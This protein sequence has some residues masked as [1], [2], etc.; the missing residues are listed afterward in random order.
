MTRPLRALILVS[1]LAALAATAA[2]ANATSLT[3][4]PQL[5]PLASVQFP[6]RAFVLTA[7]VPVQLGSSNV[8]V[9]ENG[10]PVNNVSV[11]RASK[12]ASGTFGAVLVV[13]A[14]DSMRGAAI[15]GAVQAA[16]EF[17]AHKA[18]N[19][20]LGVVT[21]NQTVH[22]LVAPTT[23]AKRVAA[24]LARPP[25]LV[26]GTHLYDAAA[27][28]VGALSRAK[29]R[30]GSLV[31]LTDGRDTRSRLS[32]AEVAA[33]ARAAH[34]RVFAVGLRSPQYTP[35]PLRLIA[36]ETGAAYAEAGSAPAL[37]RIYRALSQRLA[38]EY[39]LRYRSLAAPATNVHVQVAAVGVPG[40]A[41][42]SY[43]TPALPT[44][45]TPPFHRSFWK[46][47]VLAPGSMVVVSLL[48]ALFA[49]YAVRRILWRRDLALSERIGAFASERSDLIRRQAT[50]P[51]Q[52]F[53][54]SVVPA[55]ER[56]FARYTW[57]EQF[58]QELEI[59]RF[60]VG[61]V[62]LATMTAAG[63]LLLA[64]VL[65][66]ASPILSV[67]ALAVPLGIHTLYKTKLKRIR[68]AFAE[69][70]AGNLSVLAAS[71][72]AGHSFSSA[73]SSVVDEAEE[74]SQSEL[75]RAV[76]D[77]Q[78][79]VPVED[80]LLRVA[81]RMANSDLEQVALVASLQRET[82]GNTAEI[83]DAVVDACRERLELRRLVKA[84]TA[85]GRI[86]RWIL[87][88]LP[89]FVAGLVLLLN[90]GYLKPLVSTTGGQ[91]MLAIAIGLLI[92]GSYSI[93]RITDIE[94]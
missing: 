80:A 11:L 46:R 44:V 39:L 73:L 63:T 41:T 23:D 17:L 58:V 85:Q 67:L 8:V 21:F 36:S 49:W 91:V 60:P 72:R 50:T 40:I 16:R 20:A 42:W 45:A 75:R 24:A 70:L 61:P 89:L 3:R 35:R 14:S 26:V 22:E 92:V 2:P 12:V 68:D 29:V 74:P 34:V 25:R 55:A 76:T 83:L 78:L 71:L 18:P 66:L 13:D 19:A 37:A 90:P 27:A 47:F 30:A 43:Q 87:T 56:F 59:A 53:L 52:W 62:P 77:G 10:Q 33:K 94:L 4:A 1:A 93:K 64:V 69:Q 79:G 5:T 65:G 88:A 32:A 48:V 7:S 81:A 51:R 84:L 15:A 31:L 38:S 6:Y 54:A 9:R 86:S 82:G 28:A 57:W